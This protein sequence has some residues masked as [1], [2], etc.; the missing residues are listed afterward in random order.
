VSSAVRWSAA[1]RGAAL[2]LV[3]PSTCL[4]CGGEL[5]V[6][7]PIGEKILLCRDCHDGLDLFDEPT[8][9]RCAAPLPKS[10]REPDS[11][12]CF[13]CRHVK[14]RFDEAIG[15]GLYEGRLRELLLQMKRVEGDPMSLAIAQL[16]WQRCGERLA[17]LKVHVVAPIPLH[18]RRRLAQ[19]TNSAAVM[20]EV[21][22]R[23][24]GI[25]LA[26]R[27]LR[28]R[29]YTLRQ[30]E[31]SPP[32]R[33]ENVRRAFCVRTGYHLQE[34]HVLLVDDILTT[35]ATCSEAARALREAGAARVSVVVAARAIG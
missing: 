20:A 12:G 25:P 22:S 9:R 5:A 23:R 4:S 16:L 28:R 6:A 1:V 11:M 31:L 30:F 14:L 34:A 27:L 3:F 24:L 2:D 19:R 17:S 7:E 8:C 10:S 18:W 26:E 21:L 15:A 35:G 13:R 33:W 32:Q 29:R